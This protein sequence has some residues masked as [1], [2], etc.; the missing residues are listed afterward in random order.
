[1]HD[2]RDAK[3]QLFS[4]ALTL[5]FRPKSLHWIELN[6]TK[7][8]LFSWKQRSL[9]WIWNT[10]EA[11]RVLFWCIHQKRYVDIEEA[12]WHKSILGRPLGLNPRQS[13][14]FFQHL[15]SFILTIYVRWYVAAGFFCV[16]LCASF[17]LFEREH[18]QK[19]TWKRTAAK[20]LLKGSSHF[21]PIKVLL[22]LKVL[23][24]LKLVV[25]IQ[26]C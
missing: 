1:M 6:R 4:T 8:C 9:I 18:E 25:K 14:E 16:L 24:C 15:S 10:L 26:L 17:W 11:T 22:F 20:T 12:H 2:D 3:E 21:C 13:A 19:P 7:I 23:L 5:E